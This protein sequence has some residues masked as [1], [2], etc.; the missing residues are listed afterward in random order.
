MDADMAGRSV[1]E[2]SSSRDDPDHDTLMVPGINEDLET[3]R[4]QSHD[5]SAIHGAKSMDGH[6]PEGVVNKIDLNK[7]EYY[8]DDDRTH[9]ISEPFAAIPP[10]QPSL[11]QPQNQIYSIEVQLSPPPN[12]DLYQRLPP[13]WEVEK[14]LEEIVTDENTWF[15]VEFD[16]GRIDQVSM[17]DLLTFDNGKK[18]LRRFRNTQISS[19]EQEPMSHIRIKR[20]YSGDSGSSE[21]GTSP[22]SSK[23]AVAIIPLRRSKRQ[24]TPSRQNSVDHQY[25][26]EELEYFDPSEDDEGEGNDEPDEAGNQH[27]RGFPTQKQQPRPSRRVTRLRNVVA[28]SYKPP[29][30]SDDEL[31]E[32]EDGDSFSFVTSDLVSVQASAHKRKARG[33]PRRRVPSSNDRDSSIEFKSSTRKSTRTTTT[34]TYAVPDIDDDF[35][36]VDEK[37]NN[38]PKYTSVKEIFQPLPKSSEF[39]KMHSQVCET[40]QAGASAGKGAL[41]CCQGCSYAYHKVCLGQRSARE[42]RVTKIGSDNFVLQCRVC[43]GIYRK[44][45]HLA[46]DPAICQT[47]KLDNAS[48]REFSPKLTPKAEEKL[49]AD[50]GGEDPV[51]EIS[52][53]L[54]HNAATLLFRCTSCRR[55]FHF[56]HL[57]PLS[58]DN[59]TSD[60]LRAQRLMECTSAGWRCKDCVNASNRIQSLVAWR[61]VNLGSYV[62]GTANLDTPEDDKEY[63]VKW[64]SRSHFHNTWMPGAWIFG[65]AAAAMRS[66]FHRR[67][68]T[69]LPKMTAEDAVEEEWL[70]ADVFLAVRYRHNIAVTSK[71]KDL[72]RWSDVKEVFVKFQGLNYTESVWD[73]PPSRDSGAA[74]AAFMAA[75]EEYVNGVHFNQVSEHKM[76]ERVRRFRSLDF[77]TNCE[78]TTQPEGL[79]HGKL[80]KYQLEG[81]NWIL[82][83]FHKEQNVILADEMGLGKTVQVVALITTLVQDSPRCWP[84]LIVVPS[85]TCPNWRRELKRWA[86][87][88]RV[89]TYYG[90]KGAQDLAYRHELFPDGVKAGMKAH[91]VIASYESALDIKSTFRSVKWT[92]LIVDEGQRLKN[93]SSLLYLALREMDIPFRLLLTGTPLQN[94]KR[95]LFNLLQFVDSSLDAAELDARY[96]ELSK[97]NIRELHKL[98]RPYFLRRTK[99]QVLKFLPPMAQIIVPV[100][101]TFLQEKLSKSIIA[102]NPELIKAIVS[103]GKI[104]AGERKGLNNILMELRRCL[105]HPF[106]FSESVEDR[107][108]TDHSKMHQNLVEASGKLMLLSIMLP[109]LKQRGHRVLIFSQFLLSL[110]IIEDFLTGLGFQHARIDGQLSALE[111]QKRIDAFNAPDSPLFAMLLSTRA[112][113]VGINL[114]TA[115]TVIIYDPD[116]NPHQ[117]IQ[118]L[119]R[120]HRIGQKDKVLCFQLMT[121]DTVEEKIMQIGR[122]KM[123]LDHALIESMESS[124]DTGDDLESILKHG[125]GALF[126]DD[127]RNRITYDEESVAK[128]LDRSQIE[129]TNTGEDE[130]AESQFSFARV[131]Q[132]ATN[133]L[134]ENL[135]SGAEEDDKSS[136]KNV[137][138]NILKLRQEEHE[139]EA[140]ANQQQYGRGARR[141]NQ[142]DVRYDGQRD[143][144]D[145]DND[146]TVKDDYI[147]IE[148]D[149]SEG[150]SESLAKGNSPKALDR[151]HQLP[152]PEPQPHPRKT[153]GRPRR[154]QVGEPKNPNAMRQKLSASQQQLYQLEGSTVHKKKET[155]VPVPMMSGQSRLAQPHPDSSQRQQPTVNPSAY[156]PVN[157]TTFAHHHPGGYM[158]TTHHWYT[159]PAQY[160]SGLEGAVAPNG[161]IHGQYQAQLVNLTRVSPP[162]AVLPNASA[163]KPNSA[164]VINSLGTLPSGLPPR[165]DFSKHCIVCSDRHPSL[166]CVNFNSEI[167]I[168]IALDLIRTSRSNPTAIN[169][170]KMALYNRLH[171][172]TSLPR[173]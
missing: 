93:D 157:N 118:A 147:G 148:E 168:R 2:D 101:M 158:N 14:I 155:P 145:S 38:M 34:Q 61:P 41:V 121:K 96:E 4:R 130:S 100:T 114:A 68:D 151:D 98:I 126:N 105:C 84:F 67:D 135:D 127:V 47:C 92:G 131:W 107:T 51:T 52:S 28:K 165:M 83:N 103:K 163:H 106:L 57:P 35:E 11:T 86:P 97:E 140:A 137:W 134:A 166:S 113:G 73:C 171:Q 17:D 94:N 27:N 152:P 48:C 42:H 44:K 46:P 128:L 20:P 170:V 76:S 6:S 88:L 146:P 49:R 69:R 16:D 125:A 31:A 90:G 8:N 167:S 9:Q 119:S 91:I 33:R 144:D 12:P 37:S 56:E 74:W 169:G 108:I 39:G 124:E 77:D 64:E 3:S 123:A 87:D 139:R 109:Q 99:A 72:A 138:E 164:Q 19:T 136:D 122:K 78:L 75:Y 102:K 120:A 45:D 53:E 70:L 110:T 85:S 60:D 115:D 173:Q 81:V 1:V 111:K 55:G 50:N 66:A 89:V 22:S 82:Y 132:N 159:T 71:A 5:S 161:H 36:L 162:N 160:A 26:H 153:R 142:K 32:S 58:E 63:L 24:K 23:R 18:A 25:Y 133:T 7:D 143:I 29:Q 156:N 40:C 112:G 30:Y 80:M 141:R 79:K 65:T 129:T 154:A 10:S 13:S 150:Y 21:V 117:D 116:F 95:E 149:D 15:S 43:I 172:F 54:V 62:T 59:E 104:K